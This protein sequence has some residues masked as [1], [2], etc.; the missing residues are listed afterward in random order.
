ML[1]STEQTT[2]NLTLLMMLCPITLK[3]LNSLTKIETFSWV[4]SL[5]VTHRYAVTEVLGLIPSSED[6]Y[7]LFFVSWC[8]NF[9]LFDPKSNYLSGS[10]ADPFAM[11]FFLIRYTHHT[12]TIVTSCEKIKNKHSICIR[13]YRSIM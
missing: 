3:Q 10:V 7:V 11:C 13:L 6:F 4:C 1:N 12:A 2:L 8:F 5:E 9:T